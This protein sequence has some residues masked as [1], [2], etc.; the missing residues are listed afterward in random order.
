MSKSKKITWIFIINILLFII[1]F[2]L[3]FLYNQNYPFQNHDTF[4]SFQYKY[5]EIW[6]ISFTRIPALIIS[7]LF[8]ET[9]PKLLNM[10]YADFKI[11]Y[12]VCTII[13]LIYLYITILF[14]QSFYIGK[15]CFVPVK[16]YLMKKETILLLPVFFVFM[17]YSFGHDKNFCGI[18][19]ELVM[20]FEYCFGYIVCF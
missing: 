20:Y 10:H 9:F 2:C 6:K 3:T 15:K 16:K 7:K 5:H 1:L 11:N 19:D 18:S 14:S 17:S 13:S 12:L 4:N 8:I